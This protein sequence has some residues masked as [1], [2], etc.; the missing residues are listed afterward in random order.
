MIDPQTWAKESITMDEFLYERLFL[1]VSFLSKV[2]AC[3][4]NR[5]L[6]QHAKAE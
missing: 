1:C 2:Q 5:A 6:L 4:K 3:F